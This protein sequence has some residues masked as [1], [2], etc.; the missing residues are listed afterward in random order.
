MSIEKVL[1][2]LTRFQSLAICSSDL[3]NRDDRTDHGRRK[4]STLVEDLLEA[5]DLEKWLATHVEQFRPHLHVKF[6]ARIDK[7]RDRFEAIDKHLAEYLERL[8]DSMKAHA[9]NDKL[10]AQLAEI[11]DLLGQPSSMTAEE[12]IALLEGKDPKCPK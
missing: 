9:E 11:C 8:P 4:M 12:M 10:R 3:Q 6:R 5:L 7:I 1:R 2:M